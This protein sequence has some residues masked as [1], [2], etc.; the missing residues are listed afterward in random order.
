MWQPRTMEQTLAAAK[1]GDVTAQHFLGYYH[2]EGLGGTTNYAE[3]L[4][5]YKTAAEAKF[6]NSLNNLGMIYWYG[7]GLPQD[8]QEAE[9]YYRLAAESGGDLFEMNLANFLMRARRSSSRYAEAMEILRKV[10]SNGNPQAKIKYGW[11]LAYPSFN[12]PANPQKAVDILKEAAASGAFDAYAYLADVY[13]DKRFSLYDES[14][15]LNYYQLGADKGDS[16]CMIGMGL[17]SLDAVKGTEHSRAKAVEWFL[18]GAAQNNEKAYHFLARAYSGVGLVKPP[19]D[20]KTDYEKA[21]DYYHK[22]FNAGYVESAYELGD[23]IWNGKISWKK[24]EEALPE[25]EKAASK[26]HT[27]A[28]ETLEEITLNKLANA[29]DGNL[30]MESMAASGNINVLRKLISFYQSSPSKRGAAARTFRC[31]CAAL[32]TGGTSTGSV[33]DQMLGYSK[34]TV[35]TADGK[36]VRNISFEEKNFAPTYR[37]IIDAILQRKS[38]YLSQMAREFLDESDGRVKDAY[39]ASIWFGLAADFGALDA[40]VQNE[41]LEKEL[42]ESQVKAVQFWVTRL[43]MFPQIYR[44]Q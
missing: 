7:R 8:L 43:K 5:W 3:G 6:P 25:F 19:P 20:F 28:R 33:L 18:K 4:K 11:N 26:G 17:A 37:A 40:K 14:V 9:R 36:T 34:F 15:A 31:E 23:L 2:T 29:K 24:K 12:R 41:K 21:E 38:D 1:Q 39:E 32:L 16:A 27:K 42:S 22:A 35:K 30:Q 13:L 10:S 44:Q